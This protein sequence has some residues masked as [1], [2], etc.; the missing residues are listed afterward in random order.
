MSLS[1]S[2]LQAA[3]VLAEQLGACRDTSSTISFCIETA[4]VITAHPQ[5]HP[6]SGVLSRGQRWVHLKRQLRLRATAAA[7]QKAWARRQLE[8]DSRT[9]QAQYEA[10]PADAASL[11]VWRQAHHLL[12]QLNAVQAG[13][14]WQHYGEQSTFWF[15]HLARERQAQTMIHTSTEP[16]QTFTL[17]SFESTQ[18]AAQALETSYS[19]S[20]PQGLFA[21]PETSLAPRMRSLQLLSNS[22]EREQLEMAALLLRTSPR[23]SAPCRGARHQALMACHTSATGRSQDQSSLLF[24]RKPTSQMAQHSCL[25]T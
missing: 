25:Q 20:T 2:K 9:A 7:L 14:V 6:T 23:P 21:P 11:L 17:D 10:N 8:T 12:Q 4:D 15:Y 19:A 22:Q 1:A 16:L 5:D 18:Q 24:A 3:H 13:V